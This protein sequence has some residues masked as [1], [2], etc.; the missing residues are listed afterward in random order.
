M[1]KNPEELLLDSRT[2]PRVSKVSRGIGT[3]AMVLV[4]AGGNLVEKASGA[5]AYAANEANETLRNLTATVV[6]TPTITEAAGYPKPPGFE[7]VM[8]IA[9]LLAITY[10][11]L[12]R[13]Q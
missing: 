13:K 9:G 12:R 6:P 7:A 4:Y 8:A 3:A 1:S 11:V 2:W 10:I 5:I